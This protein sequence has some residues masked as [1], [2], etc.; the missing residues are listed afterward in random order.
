MSNNNN[1][2]SKHE[3]IRPFEWLT[4]AESLAGPLSQVLQNFGTKP[5]R[6]LHVGCGSSV[7]GE[8]LVEQHFDVVS[9]VINID[10]DKA[11]LDSMEERWKRKCQDDD[12]K[13]SKMKF[14]CVDLCQESIPLPDGSVDLVVDKSTLDCLLC[15]DKGASLLIC[16]CYRLL[17]PASGVYLAIS[18]HHVNLLRPLLQDCPGTHWTF[19]HSVMYRHVEAL[20]V[21]GTPQ[22]TTNLAKVELPA[23]PSH[24]SSAWTSAGWFQPDEVYHRTVNVLVVRRQTCDDSCTMATTRL[25]QQ[26]VYKHVNRCSDEWYQQQNPLLTTERTHQIRLAFQT[27]LGLTECYQKLFTDEEREHLTFEAF[28][29]DW[30]TFCKSHPELV[31]D[32]MSSETA[33][34]FLSEM[35]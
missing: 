25:N 32:K 18:F 5:V 15:S 7:L 27:A 3:T 1:N 8:Y 10:N 22:V 13:T 31:Q 33:L 11:I 4:S 26:D 28:L 17:N 30:T 34:R 21:G 12:D 2:S 23:P 16:E 20:G 24:S 14:V 29:E 9:Q 19:E 35:Q 6:V